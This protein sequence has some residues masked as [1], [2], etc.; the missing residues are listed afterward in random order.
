[1]DFGCHGQ[2]LVV[3]HEVERQQ[4]RGRVERPERRI[5]NVSLVQGLRCIVV[6]GCM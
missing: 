2:T 6:L 4:A 1:M 5:P 3:R